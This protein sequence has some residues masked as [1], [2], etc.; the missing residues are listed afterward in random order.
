MSVGRKSRLAFAAFLAL[1]A[2]VTPAV[3]QTLPP[4]LAR[5]GTLFFR[6]PTGNALSQT[7]TITSP[8]AGVTVGTLSVTVS[9]TFVG[10][11]LNAKAGPTAGTVVV[12]VTPPAA[13]GVYT[14][15]VDVSAANFLAVR[16]KVI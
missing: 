4:L 11:W 10:S 16:I 8:V 7:V 13:A 2:T 9:T 15:R 5:P 3:A 1:A 6:N 14:G 12:T